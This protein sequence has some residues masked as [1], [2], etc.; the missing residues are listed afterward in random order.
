MISVFGMG[1]FCW[2]GHLTATLHLIILRE[3]LHHGL[4]FL[5]SEYGLGFIFRAEYIH[6]D[7]SPH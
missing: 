3:K 2:T 6:R 5:V 7:A 4:L 1:F